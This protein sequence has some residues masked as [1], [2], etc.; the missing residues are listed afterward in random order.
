MIT[1]PSF[2]GKGAGGLGLA[3]AF[4]HNV[5]SQV[6][7]GVIC[8]VATL[9]CLVQELGKSETGYY[10]KNWLLVYSHHHYSLIFNL[11]PMLPPL[12]D[13]QLGLA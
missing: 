10:M 9:S 6:Q 13:R 5:K 3:L 4:L 1:P 2:V 11:H 7:A 12:A 8:I